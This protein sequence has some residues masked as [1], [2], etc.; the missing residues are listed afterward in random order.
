MKTAFLLLLGLAAC[1]GGGGSCPTVIDQA[2]SAAELSGVGND[3]RSPDAGSDAGESPAPFSVTS[4]KTSLA[5]A[6]D[7]SD[8]NDHCLGVQF[9]AGRGGFRIDMRCP[10]APGTFRLEDLG[11]KFCEATAGIG[12][13]GCSPVS[14]TLTVRTIALPCAGVAT[15]GRLDADLDVVASNHVPTVSGHARLAFS[16][17]IV[18]AEC[19]R[20]FLGE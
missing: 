2:T 4:V 1:G 15:C 20:Y 13:G 5:F 10:D 11:A 6:V 9:D 17:S 14:G 19:P 7:N 8:T 16:Q 3:P 18:V 12:G